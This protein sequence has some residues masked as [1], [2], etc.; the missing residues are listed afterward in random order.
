MA[1]PE[2]SEIYAAAALCFHEKYLDNVVEGGISQLIEDFFPEAE[3]EVKKNVIFPSGSKMTKQDLLTLFKDIDAIEDTVPDDEKGDVLVK[4]LPSLEGNEGKRVTEILKNMI[5]GISA[6]K[7]IKK[8]MKSEH[9]VGNPV[10]DKVYLTGDKWPTMVEPLKVSAHGFDAYNSSDFIIR[11]VGMK[12]AYFGVSLKKKFSVAAA[13]PTIINK[14][15]D[16]LIQGK[17]LDDTRTRLQQVRENYF[18]KLVK[19]AISQGHI[20][21]KGGSSKSNKFLFN[22]HKPKDRT[23]NNMAKD[24]SFIDT[25]GSMQMKEILGPKDFDKNPKLPVEKL[26]GL[27]ADDKLKYLKMLQDGKKITVTKSPWN[28]YGDKAL[29][30]SGLASRKNDTMRGWVNKQLGK[31]DA[32]YKEFMGVMNDNKDL[33][34]E[35]LI[36][37]ALKKDLPD[38]MNYDRMGDMTFG[39]A[40][41]TGIGGVSG[42]KNLYTDKGKINLEK[43]KVLDI[44]DVRCGLAKMDND[45]ADYEFKIVGDDVDTE[46]D[47][48]PAKVYFDLVKGSRTLLNME[49]RYK[50]G[51]TSQPQFFATISQ[52]FIDI[53]KGKC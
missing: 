52:D 6:A 13:D 45:A 12:N 11:P 44:M 16:T 42:G 5:V 1:G 34:V 26:Y 23:D 38:L 29:N 46:S 31:P 36:Q 18:G 32:L 25:K 10:A 35:N 47:D 48:G 27:A 2:P 40:L 28:Y 51:F 17:E 19:D 49:L 20:H 14:A 53:V 15:F 8:W 43:G 37:V 33:F 41:V 4:L 3:K 50:G 30:R 24:R 9:G 21:I 22:G 7:A 39:F